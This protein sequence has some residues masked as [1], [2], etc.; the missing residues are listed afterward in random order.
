MNNVESHSILPIEDMIE[1]DLSNK[2]TPEYIKF[3]ADIE[4]KI[5]VDSSENL[6]KS[7]SYPCYKKDSKERLNIGKSDNI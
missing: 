4:A 3:I 2:L 7:H 6:D 1:L 5:I